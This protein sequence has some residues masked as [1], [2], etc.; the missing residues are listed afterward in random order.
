MDAFQTS[1]RIGDH[2]LIA[3]I[4]EGSYGQV[5]LAQS[6]LGTYRALK[7][8]QQSRFDSARPFQ[9]EF[10]GIQR[11]E[12]VSR[13]HEGLVDILQVGRIS[14]DSFYYI[15]ELADDLNTGQEIVPET[16]QP[17]TLTNEL[18]RQGPLPCDRC[19]HIGLA[20]C[21]T[22][23]FL[24]E[25]GLIHRD[26]KPSNVIFVGD[27]PKL[28]DIGLVTDLYGAKT[29]VGTA[30]F[31]PPEGPN[32]P[33]AD[34]YGLGKLLYE[35]S[36]GKDR[37]DFPA[38]PDQQDFAQEFLE[39]NEVLV[40]A[41]HVEVARRYQSAA[42]MAADLKLIAAGRSVRRL[43]HLERKLQSIR[44]GVLAVLPLSAIIASVA[45]ALI[46][47]HQRS[48][49]QQ[50]RQIGSK[51]GQGTSLLMEGD[52]LGAL[53]RFVEALQLER[54]PVRD[55][56]THRLRIQTAWA[57]SPRVVRSWRFPERPIKSCAVHGRLA[58]VT[59]ERQFTRVYDLESGD[60]LSDRLGVGSQPEEAAFTPDGSKVVTA[61][62]DETIQII[63]WRTGEV[64]RRLEHPGTVF[65]VAVSP[66]GRSILSGGLGGRVTLWDLATGACQELGAPLAHNHFVWCVKFSPGG[67]W[68]ISA[69]SDGRALVWDLANAGERRCVLR[70][71]S[72]IY[73]ADFSPDEQ[74]IATGSF[75]G[76]VKIWDLQ[77][78]EER[79]P[80]LRHGGGVFAVQFSPDGETILSGC[81][82]GKARCWSRRTHQLLERNHTLRHETRL[83]DASFDATGQEV[84]TA[85]IDGTLT[86]WSLRANAHRPERFEPNALPPTAA[87]DQPLW[88][89]VTANGRVAFENR[90]DHTRID[91]PLKGQPSA[92]G[93]DALGSAAFAA[94]GT[95]LHL[96][97]LR[98]RTVRLLPHPD[99]VSFA[100]FSQDGTKLVCASSNVGLERRSALMW[101]VATG[102]QLGQPLPHTDG[103][104]FAAFSPDGRRVVTT[105][106]DFSA[107]VWA[108]PSGKRLTP[109]LEH[110]GKVFHACFS[111]HQ[112]WVATASDDRT[113]MIWDSR[114]GDPLIPPLVHSRPLTRVEFTRDDAA[115]IT[116][117]TEGT[118]WRWHLVSPEDKSSLARLLAEVHSMPGMQTLEE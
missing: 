73:T 25:R 62:W 103:I 115:L 92:A 17:R 72:W 4:S 32:S 23:A 86:L 49:E 111:H 83:Y 56:A 19:I 66:D 2:A 34:I 10:E 5:W 39:L 84:L 51:V 14:P 57:A 30:G 87:A 58:V 31:I 76:E 94:E 105:S 93:V 97:D 63:D 116:T 27:Q 100:A 109:R 91:L 59:F 41:C 21:R 11:F 118:R 74:L 45:Y 13:V 6:E 16:Y 15:M 60:A 110:R 101:D 88:Q 44:K 90:L 104:L 55:L 52:L 81:L 40:K 69:S 80:P 113:A 67:R 28:A 82:D 117:D 29:F 64:S 18:A 26:I 48:L 46:V 68:A 1:Q 3:R 89:L 36:T 79:N 20:L 70:H 33:Q 61:N 98:R 50:Q 65:S 114:T 77:S 95:G 85:G 96:V 24:H 35:L 112:Q 71:Q 54:S 42:E 12:P 47:N 22:L 106:E 99:P 38:L 7:I 75:D 108:V 53:P 78:G 43:H 8:V 37:H 102:T 9:R 107:L